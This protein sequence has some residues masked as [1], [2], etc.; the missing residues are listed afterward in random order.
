MGFRH[1]A[2]LQIDFKMIIMILEIHFLSSSDI[3]YKFKQEVGPKWRWSYKQ[4]EALLNRKVTED[5]WMEQ[6]IES[7]TST[8]NKPDRTK[9]GGN[10]QQIQKEKRIS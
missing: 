10:R 3:S 2:K 8:P 5:A 4:K 6:E 1:T 7:R 9:M